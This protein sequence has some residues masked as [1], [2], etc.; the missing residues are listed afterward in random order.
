MELIVFGPTGPT[1]RLLVQEALDQGHAVTAFARR[2]ERLELSHPLLRVV[3]GDVTSAAEVAAAVPGHGAVLVALGAPPRRS[4]TVRAVGT[5]HVVAAMQA[6][7]P[8][9]LVVLSSLGVGDSSAVRLPALLRW[10]IVPLVL[11]KP[12]EDH[13]EQERVVRTSGLDWTIVRPGSMKDRP[14]S[15]SFRHGDL[16]AETGLRCSVARADVA[17]FVLDQ[18]RQDTYVGCAPAL[19]D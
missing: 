12:F 7:G 17:A 6:G 19:S 9:R 16:S 13:E 3:Q 11:K 1:G 2:P 8:R 10:V 15:G 5:A 4:S 14:A 18:L